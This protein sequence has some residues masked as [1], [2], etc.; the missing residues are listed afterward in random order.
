[1]AHIHTG[2]SCAL[3]GLVATT[4]RAGAEEENDLLGVAL[5]DLASVVLSMA[6]QS[7]WA[8]ASREF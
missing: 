6:P 3:T 4:L 1:M 5:S 8:T 2:T 7:M